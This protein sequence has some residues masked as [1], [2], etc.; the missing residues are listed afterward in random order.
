MKHTKTLRRVS[1]TAMLLVTFFLQVT[2][3]LAG[4]T[5]G[6]S[7]V[8]RDDRGAPVASATVSASS[9]SGSSTDTTD[10]T[11]HFSFLSLNPDTY[12]VSV[13]KSG[14]EQMSQPGVVV[15]ADQTQTL[16]LQTRRAPKEIGRVTARSASAIVKPGQVTDVYSVSATVQEA[17]SALGGGGNL[18]NAYSAIQSVPGTYMNQGSA[19][20]SQSI[21][22]RGGDYTEVS[23]EYDGIPVQRSFDAYPSNSLSA[24]GQQELQIYTGSPPAGS[25]AEG[26]SGYINQVI[27][28]GTYP[29]YV[30]ADLAAGAPFFYHKAQLEAGG[31]T[32]NHLFSYY[33]ATAG[34]NQATTIY[35]R[36]FADSLQPTFGTPFNVLKANCGKPS[37]TLGCYANSGGLAGTPIGPNGIA[38]GPQTYG[39]AIYDIDRETVANFHFGLPHKHDSGRDDIQLL[40]DTSFL[41]TPIQD[42]NIW[43]GA[44]QQDVANGTITMGGTT[45]ANCGA[46]TP[47]APCALLGPA[48]PQYSDSLLYTGPVNS[49]LTNNNLAQVSPYFYPGS[50]QNRQLGA[51]IN[52]NQADGEGNSF[53]IV[54]LQYQKNW[55][56]A[57][58]RI[59]GYSFY[60]DRLDNA[61]AGLVGNLAGFGVPDYSVISHTH[62]FA[63][64]F[65]DQINAK[66]LLT[67]NAL[68]T[69]A[70]N[71]RDNQGITYAPAAQVAY[72]VNSANPTGGCY[73]FNGG[74]P[75]ASRCPA[76]SG[77]TLGTGYCTFCSNAGGTSV[78]PAGPFTLKPA[79]GLPTGFLPSMASEYNCGNG[80][81]EFLTTDNG[82]SGKFNTVKPAFTTFSLEDEIRPTAKLVV[83]AALRY[84]DFKFNLPQTT[85]GLGRQLLVNDY[86]LN[87]CFNDTSK[88][89]VPATSPGV[90][91][92]GSA[93]TQFT[94]TSP[95]SQDYNSYQ[96]RLGATYTPNDNNVFRIAYGKYV[97]PPS[98]AFEQYDAHEANLLKQD[99]VFYPL[100]FTS[101][102]HAVRPETTYN[103]DGSWEHQIKGSDISL[104]L[105]P[106][107]RNSKDELITVLINPAQNF[108][109]AV[110]AGNERAYGLEA[111]LRKGDF[112]RNGFSGQVSYTYTHARTTYNLLQNGNSVVLG[113]NN[114][115]KQYNGYTRTC[116]ATAQPG[117]SNSNPAC[118]STSNGAPAAACYTQSGTADN[119]CAPGDIA[120]PY[121][122]DNARPLFDPNGSYIPFDQFPSA[123]LSGVQGSFVAPHVIAAILNYKHDKLTITPS[124]Q[125]SAG[126]RYGAPVTSN[127]IDPAGGCAPLAGATTA[128]D[129]RYP[130]GA[131]G[132]APYD[133]QTCAS[134]GI[135]IPNTYTNA[136]D[137]IGQFT[138]PTHF[139][140]NMQVGYQL[141]PRVK[142]NL[143]FV[144]LIDSCFG[145]SKEPWTTGDQGGARVCAYDV[146]FASYTVGNFY[147]PGNT[148]QPAIAYPYG[149]QFASPQSVAAA[150]HYP[151][152]MYFSVNLKL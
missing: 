4:T 93:L 67:F 38:F 90:C 138:E 139:T 24:L 21:F 95:S 75:T 23:Y 103:I 106:F 35:D 5:G 96:P 66:N 120:N 41:I 68:Y 129:P 102:A 142:A 115:I 123:G 128:N 43:W 121:W 105:S 116:A 148:I 6:L 34:F 52:N 12:V 126:T 15:F 147:N 84:D 19:G 133:A 20:H 135:P 78:S 98:T 127:G 36:S 29:S 83:K 27:K 2:W 55:A 26:L 32:S 63:G 70:P 140:A 16:D 28:T 25:A 73:S 118:G 45:Y 18:N 94:T 44:H 114:S 117:G 82:Q 51:F 104:S 59:Y 58:A 136:F 69:V 64:T 92:A 108:V 3:A 79:G 152:Q 10:A 107:Y 111:F 33:I 61:P 22:V 57:F 151:F 71:V 122:L 56:N 11:G 91:P 62:G 130:R 141:S 112:N 65:A 99:A 9:L 77:Y 8:V 42:G 143:V 85:G 13:S 30:S 80:P 150:G 74:A 132:G 119:S 149:P 86:N 31:A 1:V 88:A 46:A 101:P 49:V 113:V 131:A 144:N 39:Q 81:C 72:L 7:G 17:A 110:N 125:L 97:Q 37:A 89:V 87:H 40:Y 109:S 60:S 124:F 145:G 14:Y 137:Q 50:P 47:G 54:K 134:N 146:P 100:G 48:T 53:S 76:A